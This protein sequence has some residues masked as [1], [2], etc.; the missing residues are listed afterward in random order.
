MYSR[1]QVGGIGDRGQSIY[2]NATRWFQSNINRM[3]MLFLYHLRKSYGDNLWTVTLEGS[4]RD[5]WLLP[6]SPRTEFRVEDNTTFICSLPEGVL[7]CC[8]CGFPVCEKA[9]VDIKLLEI[10][11]NPSAWMSLGYDLYISHPHKTKIHTSKKTEEL[12]YVAD[13]GLNKVICYNNTSKEL[14]HS[15]LHSDLFLSFFA[16]AKQQKGKVLPL[17]TWALRGLLKGRFN[18]SRLTEIL[19]LPS[20]KVWEAVGECLAELEEWPFPKEICSLLLPADHPL[21]LS[22]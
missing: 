19:P 6:S 22:G 3:Y 15:L 18:F 7:A 10:W 21:L 2:S 13:L 4:S 5:K 17:H 16:A 12:I 9:H 20:L 8:Y 11:C 1:F 14:V